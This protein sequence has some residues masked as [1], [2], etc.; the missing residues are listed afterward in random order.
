MDSGTA[1]GMNHLFR[2]R[3]V[4]VAASDGEIGI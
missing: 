1:G 4:A 3:L 2:D